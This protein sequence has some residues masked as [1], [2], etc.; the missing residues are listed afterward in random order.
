MATDSSKREFNPFLGYSYS[1]RLVELG[2]VVLFVS[3]LSSGL[4]VVPALATT[5][6]DPSTPI[7]AEALLPAA[8]SPSGVES[9]PQAPAPASIQSPV[10]ALPSASVSAP[11]QTPERTV[12]NQVPASAPVPA[13][14]NSVFIDTTDYSLGAT[15][16]PGVSPNLVFAER[17]TGCQIT[18]AGSQT[19]L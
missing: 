3:G 2:R 13:G 18:V 5:E 11:A 4:A 6:V 12:P 1:R 14:D 16:A 15:A 10:E 19:P 17:A 7:S 9:V 8:A